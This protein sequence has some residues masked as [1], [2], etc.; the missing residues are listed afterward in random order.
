MA[1]TP[2]ATPLHER[3]CV[4]GH[5][6]SWKLQ[7]KGSAYCTKCARLANAESRAKKKAGATAPLSELARLRIRRERLIIELAVNTMEI[8]KREKK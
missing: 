6:N 8:E 7:P 4:R 3:V 5:S 2:L 1:R